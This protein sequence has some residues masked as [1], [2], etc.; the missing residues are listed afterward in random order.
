MRCRRCSCRPG[1][2]AIENRPY[3]TG[4]CFDAPAG[5]ALCRPPRQG[6]SKLRRAGSLRFLSDRRSRNAEAFRDGGWVYFMSL[7]RNVTIC[8]RV[9]GLSGLNVLAL[10]PLV[11]FFD[12]AQSTA[13]V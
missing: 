13:S 1:E 4:V 5:T 11:M 9:Q 8:P 3:G 2:R 7:Y 6:E 10:V 12:T